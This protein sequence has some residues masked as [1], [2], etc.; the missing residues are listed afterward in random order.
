MIDLELRFKVESIAEKID[1]YSSLEKLDRSYNMYYQEFNHPYL[2]FLFG[3]AYANFHENEKAFFFFKRSASFGISSPKF[4]LEIYGSSIAYSLYYLIS[5]Y[6]YYKDVYPVVYKMIANCF[7]F[8]SLHIYYR[9]TNYYKSQIYRGYLLNSDCNN[10]VQFARNY[11]NDCGASINAMLSFFDF[12]TSEKLINNLGQNDVP[13]LPYKQEAD[14]CLLLIKEDPEYKEET[15]HFI[16]QSSKLQM[17]RFF[18]NCYESYR[19]KTFDISF[20]EWNKIIH[21]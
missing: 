12:N 5:L 16:E 17:I 3:E 13:S 2:D 10:V 4:H 6:S 18:N 1:F 9:R 15:K 8:L 7:I 11:C 21:K 20:D 14:E 19:E